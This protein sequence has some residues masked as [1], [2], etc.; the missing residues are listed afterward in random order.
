MDA[1]AQVR[2]WL[3]E[4]SDW[5][6]EA[7]DRLLKH[8]N[9]TQNDIPQIASLLKTPA[10]QAISKHRTFDELTHEPAGSVL[11]LQSIA[12]VTG[13]ESLGPRAPLD[14]GEIFMANDST[15]V[16]QVRRNDPLSQ[17]L[18]NEIR[19]VGTRGFAFGGEFYQRM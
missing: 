4:Q 6:Q 7:A 14:F 10:G 19:L 3:L 2:T 1:H 8:G 12:D 16:R 9:L 13:I 17:S 18:E 15:L 5:L 11:R